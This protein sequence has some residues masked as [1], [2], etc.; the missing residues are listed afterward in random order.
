MCPE[1]R[2]VSLWG[3]W[4]QA[5]INRH[6][7]EVEE[8]NAY[9]AVWGEGNACQE[10]CSVSVSVGGQ[11]CINRRLFGVKEN[12]AYTGVVYQFGVKGMRARKHVQYQFRVQGTHV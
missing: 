8:N 7:F 1:A 12:S 3:G 10:A 6:Q 11:A 4:K 2:S 5:S 9:I